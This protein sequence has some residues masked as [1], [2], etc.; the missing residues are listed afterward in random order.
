MDSKS[1]K[2]WLLAWAEDLRG[3]QDPCRWNECEIGGEPGTR[4]QILS[5]PDKQNGNS[6]SKRCG[7]LA[8][9]AA[10]LQSEEIG[11]EQGDFDLDDLF[12]ARAHP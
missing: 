2:S 10:V 11:S 6:G 8:N 5:W 12:H 1:G 4:E 7:C 9:P 3:R